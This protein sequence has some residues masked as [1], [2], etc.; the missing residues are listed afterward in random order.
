[1]CKIRE[2]DKVS[3]LKHVLCSLMTVSDFFFRT[4]IF[5][6]II[7]KKIENSLQLIENVPP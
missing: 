2:Q 3:V 7:I 5:N 1:M 6:I 4:E